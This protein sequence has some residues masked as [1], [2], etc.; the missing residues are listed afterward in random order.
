ME[1][2]LS[3]I[4]LGK[5]GCTMM[6]CFAHKGWDVIGMDVNEL[7]VETI[8]RGQSPIDEPHVEEMINENMERITVTSDYEKAIINSDVSF[9]IVP[10]PSKEDGSFSTVYVE[11]AAMKIA[12]VLTKKN[13]YHLIVITSTV[14]PGDSL[15]I[16]YD[17]AR[18]SG[19]IL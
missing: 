12:R 16:T 8:S 1:Q 7:V 3:V 2:K 15:R 4:G 14:L 10:T 19:K 17:I 5:L 11:S 6:A 9:I 18:E 13:S